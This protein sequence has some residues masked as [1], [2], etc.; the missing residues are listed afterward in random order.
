MTEHD[1]NEAALVTLQ[2]EQAIHAKIVNA[3]A[4]DAVNI[5]ALLAP[6]VLDYIA[7]N[8][9]DPRFQRAIA[10]ALVNKLQRI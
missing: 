3:I 1:L 8:T 9:Y 6:F 7:K 10:D 5:G 4:K 2:L